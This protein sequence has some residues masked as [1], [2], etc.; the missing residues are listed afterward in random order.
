MSL[1]RAGFE[2]SNVQ[3]T[4]SV[5]HIVNFL[6]PVDQDIEISVPSPAPCLLTCHHED[7]G[8]NLSTGHRSPN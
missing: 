6:L 2:V 7:N 1:W 8:L 4:P 3:A 5:G